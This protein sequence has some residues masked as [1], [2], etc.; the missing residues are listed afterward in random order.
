MIDIAFPEK[1]FS[2]KED[3]GRELIFD[4]VRKQWLLLTPEEWVRQNFLNY[5]IN[6]K[7]CP[8]SLIAVEREIHLGELK[9]RCDIVVYKDAKPWMIVEC[10][11]MSVKL[12]DP[13]L[14]QILN[15]NIALDVSFLI[16]TNGK[17]TYGLNL[18]EKGSKWLDEVP[19][20]NS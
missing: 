9:K 15:Y 2:I 11:E 14:K 8:A 17:E 6:V 19:P 16:I 18:K 13:V 7:R 10:K 1:R 5:L 4:D 3:K 12:S 20:F